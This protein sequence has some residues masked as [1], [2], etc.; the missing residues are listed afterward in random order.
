MKRVYLYI[1]AAAVIGLLLPGQAVAAS[2]GQQIYS[3]KGE[4]GFEPAIGKDGNLQ[5]IS[6]ETA[7]KDPRV[8][9]PFTFSVVSPEGKQ[10]SGWSDLGQATY[11]ADAMG[12]ETVY[13]HNDK[14]M[15]AYSI[16][17]E[18][19]WEAAVRADEEVS[20]A[21]KGGNLY[22]ARTDAKD[23]LFVKRFTPAGQV[24]N[25]PKAEEMEM[26]L[27]ED[28]KSVVQ[29]AKG[30]DKKLSVLRSLKPNGK[31]AWEVSPFAKTYKKNAKLALDYVTLGDVDQNGNAYVIASYG[32]EVF[33]EIYAISPA[34]KLLWKK[35]LGAGAAALMGIEK[36]T[37][38]YQ[39]AYNKVDFVSR[40]T[41]KTLGTVTISGVEDS[42]DG[43]ELDIVSNQGLIYIFD[44]AGIY[45]VNT[46]G[47]RIALY[48][49]PSKNDYVYTYD[50]DEKSR[51]YAVIRGVAGGKVTNTVT[52]LSSK[53]KP[54]EQQVTKGTSLT[55]LVA[56]QT[57]GAYYAFY[58]TSSKTKP[59]KTDVV[60]YQLK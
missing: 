24:L 23:N 35:D 54:I 1:I 50:V 44:D 14:K 19:K 7:F 5:I 49:Y 51:L 21:D 20:F 56:H 37:L 36:D 42:E 34:G 9:K 41:G 11:H 52:V 33:A 10:L 13:V 45:T 30:K 38:Y 4:P 53:G 46:S 12:N 2:A 29:I 60:K 27:S 59:E 8:F 25:Y 22:T 40:K 28:G 58:T 16:L 26:G 17:H 6:D 39:R 18:K 55:G 32:K 43:R 47:K 15:T 31:T 48:P 3:F 57:S